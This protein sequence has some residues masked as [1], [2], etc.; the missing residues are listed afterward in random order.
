[1]EAAKG[2]GSLR[3]E[4][5]RRLMMSYKDD[6]MRMSYVYLKDADL[7]ENTVQ[8]TF[9]KGI[10][11]WTI[12]AARSFRPHLFVLLVNPYSRNIELAKAWLS[13]LA[14]NPTELTRCVFLNGMPDGIETKE[15][16]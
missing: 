7:A 15:S 5:L 10:S 13:Y 11:P 6:L 8:D 12:R 14:S 9:I 16:P 2:P 1:M 4:T 3:E